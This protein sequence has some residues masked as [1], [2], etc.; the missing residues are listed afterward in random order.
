MEKILSI[1][2]DES[3]KQQIPLDGNI[4]KQKALK[5]YNCLKKNGESPVEPEFVAS[6][7]WFERFKKRFVLR[8]IRIQ[9]ES[10]SVDNEVVRNYP[11]ELQK[12]IAE[13]GFLPHQV[14]NVD[15]T[16]LWWKHLSNR[17]TISDKEKTA[18]SLDAKVVAEDSEDATAADLTNQD[19]L[20]EKE[21]DKAN[22]MEMTMEVNQTDSE[23][24]TSSDENS[25]IPNLTLTSIRKG[26]NLAE[27][28]ASY[29]L[30]VDPSIERSTQFKRELQQCL[31]PYY[32][33]Y[34]NLSSDS[35][36][37]PNADFV[38]KEDGMQSLDAAEESSV[39][40]GKY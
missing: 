27:E 35:E 16:D 20:V 37:I 30:N 2:I 33:L 3:T 22:L 39:E 21:E 36:Q 7:G 18:P 14:F 19:L 13:H 8:S 15:E 32:E 1:W 5:I 17:T 9:G 38:K 25:E 31:T 11:E 34:K 10:A 23:E 24:N 12:F 26:I 6:K 40:E 29:F 28:L 4:I